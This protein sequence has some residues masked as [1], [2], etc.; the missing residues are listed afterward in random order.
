MWI[1]GALA[2]APMLVVYYFSLQ[3]FNRGIDSWFEVEV[4]RA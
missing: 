4:S 1:F 2:V 3:F